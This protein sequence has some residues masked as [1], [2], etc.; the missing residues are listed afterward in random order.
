MISSPASRTTPG[1]CGRQS[2]DGQ[3]GGLFDGFAGLAVRKVIRPTRFYYMLLQRLKN[4]R[5]MDDGVIW[6]AQADFLARLA[7]WEKASDALWPL[8]RAERAALVALNVPHFVLPS[9]G[10]NIRDADGLSVPAE[11]VSGLDRAGARLCNLDEPEIAWQVEVIRQN[12][13]TVSRVQ[14]TGR[15]SLRGKPRLAHWRGG[16]ARYRR[17]SWRR[18][19]GSPQ[20][21]SVT[22]SARGRPP[23]GSGWTGWESARLLSSRR[24]VPISTTAPAESACFSRPMRR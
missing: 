4:H 15:G 24:W 6:S 17:T 5:S 21:S 14:G 10:N 23:P 22:P 13:A 7:D 1:F 8:Q 18:P 12:T 19:T 3:Y 2:R 16:C 20:T 11:A 9:D